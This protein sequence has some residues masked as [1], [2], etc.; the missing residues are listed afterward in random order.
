M[1]FL[2][3]TVNI[4]VPHITASIQTENAEGDALCA[5]IAIH[6]NDEQLILIFPGD[7]RLVI[8][9]DDAS[10]VVATLY[11]DPDPTQPI[12]VAPQSAR[13]IVGRAQTIPF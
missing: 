11:T 10:A 5:D 1:Y 9:I 13:L 12:R 2:T 4:T 8:E 7:R 3:E 6:Q